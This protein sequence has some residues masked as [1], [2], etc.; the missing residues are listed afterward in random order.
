MVWTRPETTIGS[1]GRT[2]GFEN[3]DENELFAEVDAFC[4]LVEQAA[5]RDKFV[6]VPTWTLSSWT[7]GLGMLD[8]RKGGVAR[9]L[10]AMNLRLSD[11]LSKTSNVFVMNAERW[12]RAAGGAVSSPKGW[13]LG[14]MAM[15]RAP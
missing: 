1:F 7:R 2:L 3:I 14:K 13:Y 6:F 15:S 4:S 11:N 12:V 10:M 8:G 9:Q 5:P